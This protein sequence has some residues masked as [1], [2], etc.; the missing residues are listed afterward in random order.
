MISNTEQGS[1]NQAKFSTA[2][3]N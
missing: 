1:P 2:K 3:W